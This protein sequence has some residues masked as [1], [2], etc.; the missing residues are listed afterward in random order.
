MVTSYIV[1]FTDPEVTAFTVNPFTTDGPVAPNTLELSSTAVRA[2]SS[3]LLYGKGHPDYGERIQENL[4]NLMENFSGA[5]EPTFPV[6]GQTW[7]ARITY[8]FVGVGSPNNAS[9]F[10]WQDDSS[11]ANGGEWITLTFQGVAGTQTTDEYVTGNTPTGLTSANDGSF[12]LDTNGSPL[13][14]ELHL[15]VNNSSTNLSA[16]F[17]KR[18]MEDLTGLVGA[19]GSFSSQVPGSPLLGEYLPQKQLK[20]YDGVEWKNSGNVY[21]NHVPP[22]SSSI[23]DLWYQVGVVGSPPAG[24]PT[25]GGGGGPLSQL[26]IW[27]RP[28][29]GKTPRWLSTGYLD[30]SGDTMTGTLS[31]G[32]PLSSLF[33]WEGQGD[34][35]VGPDLRTTGNAL[36][37][38]ADNFYIHIDD[39]GSDANAGNNVF[40]IA[41]NTQSRG[42]HRSLF[43]VQSDGIIRSALPFGSPDATLGS[44]N[45]YKV[46]L[47][48]ADDNALINKAYVDDHLLTLVDLGARV[49]INETNI[50][51]LN[52]QG[53]GSPLVF[54]GSPIQAKVNRTGDTM[55]GTLF[56]SGQPITATLGSPVLGF[57]GI[58]VGSYLISNLQTPQVDTDAATKGYVDSELATFGSPDIFVDGATWE[59]AGANVLTLTRTGGLG[60]INVSITETANTTGI[61]HTVTTPFLRDTHQGLFYGSPLVF[62]S[63]LGSKPLEPTQFDINA[64]AVENLAQRLS[65]VELPYAR[66]IITVGSP[67]VE[68]VGSPGNRQFG[69]TDDSYVAGTNRLYVFVNGVKQ[70]ANER[71]HQHIN[72]NTITPDGSDIGV[73]SSSSRTSIATNLGS[74]TGSPTVAGAV[75]LYTLKIAVDGG[76]PAETATVAG[77]T[78]RIFQGVVDAINS[79]ITGA[80]AVWN[81]ANTSIDVYS[82]TTGTGSS[83][84]IIDGGSPLTILGALSTIIH[85]NDDGTP[86]GLGSPIPGGGSPDTGVTVYNTGDITPAAGGPISSVSQNLAYFEASGA[87][88]P[89]FLDA[90]FGEQVSTVVF[91]T[92]QSDGDVIELIY[93]P[94]SS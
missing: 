52:D 91:N 11:L 60:N 75:I 38:S 78:L 93:A 9:L 46:L 84:E 17:L 1:N 18:E 48:T 86:A 53:V 72:F 29:P 89:S 7:F 74:P 76:S 44:P 61:T 36:L 92:Q 63:P 77:Q 66:E 57:V 50:G 94:V 79:H 32:L 21:V 42:T 71:A 10:R 24:S 68:G 39:D 80:T 27:A 88:S 34:D 20:V 31:F 82:N 35:T 54:S 37:T 51:L 41:S 6:S 85:T 81:F 55:T 19:G 90:T 14:P 58:D 5:T 2:S 23:G 12:W 87:G 28:G 49:T 62:G 30:R 43:Q 26:F 59:T 3:L 16:G 67:A 65:T 83:I 4:I 40:E 13:V 56:F 22:S 69:F 73:F 15:Y 33:L 64:I 47:R 8:A 70:Y 25:L 45:T